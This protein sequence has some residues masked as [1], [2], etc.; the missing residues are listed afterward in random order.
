MYYGHNF[1]KQSGLCSSKNKLTDKHIKHVN[2]SLL[3]IENGK[4]QSTLLFQIV[5]MIWL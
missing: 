5:F 4:I 3:N 1:E 2:V